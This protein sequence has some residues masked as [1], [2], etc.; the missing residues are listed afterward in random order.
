MGKVT[1]EDIIK[2][3]NEYYV[4][5]SY[6]EVARRTGWSASTVK[7]YIVADF[8]PVSSNNIIKF[9]GTLPKIN[10][11]IFRQ[12]DWA[13]LLELSNEEKKEIEELWKELEI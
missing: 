5:H 8:K 4:C 3:N 11:L 7:K 2:I 10:F 6:A 9:D 12:E 13:P 1:K